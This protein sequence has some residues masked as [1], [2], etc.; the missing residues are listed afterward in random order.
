MKKVCCFIVLL[1]WL[2]T[3][4]W[5]GDKLVLPA[6]VT[7]PMTLDFVQGYRFDPLVSQLTLPTN[8]TIAGYPKGTKGYYL[9]Q[10]AGPIQFW[11]LRNSP[12]VRCAPRT[13]RSSSA[14]ISRINRRL[15]GSAGSRFRPWFIART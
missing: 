6:S 9:V 4:A 5:A 11:L 15:S 13:P 14:W 2:V 10:F 7:G 1:G 3:G 8:L 12:G